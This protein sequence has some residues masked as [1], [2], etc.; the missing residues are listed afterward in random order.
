MAG[1]TDAD[2]TKIRAAIATGVRSVTYADGRKVEY[3]NLD[4]ML[5]AEKVIAAAVAMIGVSKSAM[6]RRRVP[7]YRSGLR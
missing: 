2:L 1:F 7:Y 4:Q 3:Q 6:V 5:A